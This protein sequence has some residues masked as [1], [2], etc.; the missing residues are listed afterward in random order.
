MRQLGGMCGGAAI[1]PDRLAG[2]YLVTKQRR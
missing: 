2:Q 1:V